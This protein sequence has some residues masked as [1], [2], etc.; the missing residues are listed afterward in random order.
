MRLSTTGLSSVG[1]AETLSCSY[2]SNILGLSSNADNSYFSKIWDSTCADNLAKCNCLPFPTNV[3][4]R[5][6]LIA[7]IANEV[8]FNSVS[9][10]FDKSEIMYFSRMKDRID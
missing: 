1:I 8:F 3:L 4:Q 5:C 7:P 2:F 10:S 6:S 9:E